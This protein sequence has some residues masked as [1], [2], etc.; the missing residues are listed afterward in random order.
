MTKEKRIA[1]VRK[2]H[3]KYIYAKHKKD[4]FKTSAYFGL[5]ER[6]KQLLRN[7]YEVTEEEVNEIIRRTDEEIEK[8]GI[9]A[10]QFVALY[11]SL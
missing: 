6:A 7:E 11:H 5:E 9:E 4:G 2:F 10:D 8:A 1:D 3:I